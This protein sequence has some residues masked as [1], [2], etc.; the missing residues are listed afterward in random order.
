MNTP[1][2]TK[3]TLDADNVLEERVHSDAFHV[4]AICVRKASLF[5]PVRHSFVRVDLLHLVKVTN[6]SHLLMDSSQDSSSDQ[7]LETM[8]QQTSTALPSCTLGRRRVCRATL[9][10]AMSWE[11][12]V[13]SKIMEHPNPRMLRT[14]NT[15]YHSEPCDRCR[16]RIAGVRW[17]RLCTPAGE[18][19]STYPHFPAESP[20]SNSTNAHAASTSKP[21]N[22]QKAWDH[23]S[24]TPSHT[25][26]EH[27]ASST[28]M[29][30]YTQGDPVIESDSAPSSPR[31]EKLLR[32]V[33]KS[34]SRGLPSLSSLASSV[35]SAIGAAAAPLIASVS[36][37][38][39]CPTHTTPASTASTPQT[40]A[41][42]RKS[43]TLSRTDG[44]LTSQGETPRPT[45]SSQ[46]HTSITTPGGPSSPSNTLQGGSHDIHDKSTMS[47]HLLP[48]HLI[49]KR[50]IS[51]CMHCFD[52]LHTDFGVAP[53][54][55][56]VVQNQEHEDV[57]YKGVL[58]AHMRCL[59]DSASQPLLPTLADEEEIAR[60]DAAWRTHHSHTIH[61]SSPHPQSSSV[62]AHATSSPLNTL[63]ISSEG[64]GDATG[65]RWEKRHIGSDQSIRSSSS[66]ADSRASYPMS[67]SST[68]ILRADMQNF[69][70]STVKIPDVAD[71]HDADSSLA[72][73]VVL[74][75]TPH[76][77]INQSTN[78]AGLGYMSDED[79]SSEA[80]SDHDMAASAG[81]SSDPD[82]LD[83]HSHSSSD[84]SDSDH[85]QRVESLFDTGKRQALNFLVQDDIM[86]PAELRDAIEPFMRSMDHSQKEQA[87]T[88][89]QQQ[90]QQGQKFKTQM[91]STSTPAAAPNPFFLPP[92]PV[93]ELTP[94]LQSELAAH[95]ARSV[96]EYGL[97][98]D[99]TRYSDS[100]APMK[101]SGGLPP[102][103]ELSALDIVVHPSFERDNDP[104]RSA[105]IN[106]YGP[107]TSSSHAMGSGYSE[108][109]ISSMN[110][111]YTE[112]TA[113]PTITSAGYEAT[114]AGAYT[115]PA[116][117]FAPSGY[118][119][120]SSVGHR[121]L[122]ESAFLSHDVDPKI[123][124]SPPPPRKGLDA[125]SYS[126][127][128]MKDL[129]TPDKSEKKPTE[130]E[131]D[132]VNE[133][134]FTDSSNY[135]PPAPAANSLLEDKGHRD[136]NAEWQNLFLMLMEHRA[137][138]LHAM[139]TDPRSM[140]DDPF[141]RERSMATLLREAGVL[142]VQSIE[143]FYA[144]DPFI[145]R[146]SRS[147]SDPPAPH[148][149][150]LDEEL[151][152]M[153]REVFIDG[154]DPFS[155]LER[156]SSRLGEMTHLKSDKSMF[157]QLMLCLIKVREFL[158]EFIDTATR[159][160]KTIVSEMT[161]PL[162]AKTVRPRN[163]GGI[164]GGEKYLEEGIFFK[165]AIDA[166]NV[167]GGDKFAMKAAGHEI[168]GIKAF[169]ECELPGVCVP[170]SMLIDYSG[171]R[172]VASVR[173]PISQ[174]T[175]IYGSSDGGATI[176]QKDP[177]FNRMMQEAAAHLNIKQHEVAPGISL[178]SAVD[179][180]GHKGT[181][182]RYYVLD[183]ARIFPPEPP[184]RTFVAVAIPADSTAPHKWAPSLPIGEIELIANRARWMEQV[185][186]HLLTGH[187]GMVVS[188]IPLLDGQVFY[189]E[190][191]HRTLSI[192]SR[193]S[194]ICFSVIRGPAVLVVEPG[195]GSTQL[196]NLLRA[197]YVARQPHA[198]SSDAFTS[199]GRIDQDIHNTEVED[200]F[201]R[202]LGID[203]PN[204][205]RFLTTS[206]TTNLTHEGLITTIKDFGIN[207]RL[208]GFL[209]SH[210]P[211]TS[212][213]RAIRSMLLIEMVTR[214]A[215][216][217]LR[218][219]MRSTRSIRNTKLDMCLTPQIATR[220]AHEIVLSTFNQ[221]LGNSTSSTYMWHSFMKT[222]IICKYGQY[223]QA[224]TESELDPA[225]DLRSEVNKLQLFQ[226]LIMQ[227]GVTFKNEVLLKFQRNPEL[228]ETAAPFGPNDI[229]ELVPKLKAPWEIKLSQFFKS[230]LNSLPTIT[231]RLEAMRGYF[232]PKG[233]ELGYTALT[234]AHVLYHFEALRSKVPSVIDVVFH[235]FDST[236]GTTPAEVTSKAFFLLAGASLQQGDYALAEA[237]LKAAYNSQRRAL[238]NHIAGRPLEVGGTFLLVVLDKLAC[239]M[240]RLHRKFE[241][242]F[243]AQKFVRIWQ[244]A[245][246]PGDIKDL[247]HFLQRS[248][249]LSFALLWE[250]DYY[251]SAGQRMYFQNGL[252][253]D[254][255]G[256]VYTNTEDFI[257]SQKTA[258][259]YLK[260]NLYDEI[261]QDLPEIS[262]EVR[263]QLEHDLFKP[264]A[265]SSH[266]I[267]E[268]GRIWKG[269]V[270]TLDS[271][272][273]SGFHMASSVWKDYVN[274][275]AWRKERHFDPKILRRAVWTP[276]V[277][278]LYNNSLIRSSPSS[279][280]NTSAF[281]DD[282]EA[283]AIDE[284]VRVVLP[285][286]SPSVSTATLPVTVSD[287]SKT[288]SS[289]LPSKPI[290]SSSATSLS[291][292][293][294]QNSS[295]SSSASLLTGSVALSAASGGSNTTASETPSFISIYSTGSASV[296]TPALGVTSGN[297]FTSTPTSPTS[298]GGGALTTN[299]N[300]SHPSS[301]LNNL[302]SLAGSISAPH[303]LRSGT[304][305]KFTFT[306]HLAQEWGFEVTGAEHFVLVKYEPNV[307]ILPAFTAGRV[308][309][310]TTEGK[311]IL[312]GPE[313]GQFIEGQHVVIAS[314]PARLLRTFGCETWEN[315]DL[316]YGVYQ[317]HL[318][319]GTGL[320]WGRATSI[321]CFVL[322]NHTFV[323]N[324]TA[325]HHV[326][327][328]NESTNWTTSVFQA[329]GIA[330]SSFAFIPLGA[331]YGTAYWTDSNSQLWYGFSEPNGYV[332]N[333]LQKTF[334]AEEVMRLQMNPLI[335]PMPSDF[336][337]TFQQVAQM[338]GSDISIFAN[339]T[340]ANF[341]NSSASSSSGH[342]R[343]STNTLHSSQASNSTSGSNSTAT[344]STA[345]APAPIAG[346]GK[347]GPHQNSP[348][349]TQPSGTPSNN[350]QGQ[351]EKQSNAN[352]LPQTSTSPHT[353]SASISNATAQQASHS[354]HANASNS[355][356]V[357]AVAAAAASL[358]PVEVERA[359]SASS[360]ASHR[361][362]ASHGGST[363]S[364]SLSSS[365][366]SGTTSNSS[367]S[368]KP[369]VL[370][371]EML[372]KNGAEEK[373]STSADN[374][375]IL[376]FDASGARVSLAANAVNSVI[377][378]KSV[379]DQL[380]RSMMWSKMRKVPSL[381][382][383][384]VTKVV[385]SNSHVMAL[386]ANGDIYTWGN[387]LYGELGH[388][389]L[390]RLEEPR[391]VKRLRGKQVR[392]IAA[393]V[394]RS[395]ALISGNRTVYQWGLDFS[396][397]PEPHPFWKSLP[398]EEVVKVVFQTQ[399][400]LAT[401]PN[402]D[403]DMYGPVPGVPKDVQTYRIFEQPHSVTMNTLWHSN[404][405][406]YITDTGRAYLHGHDPY[407]ILFKDQKPILLEI[408][409]DQPVL[410]AAI[411]SNYIVF[412]GENGTI[413]TTGYNEMGQRGSGVVGD[414]AI[415]DASSNNS[416]ALLRRSGG[417][418]SGLRS[419]QNKFM[420]E[421]ISTAVERLATRASELQSEQIA[422]S[423]KNNSGSFGN[424][425][426]SG[427][428]NKN[429][430]SS[431]GGSA[432]NSG[433]HAR[434]TSSS[435]NQ[436]SIGHRHSQNSKSSSSRAQSRSSA[437][438]APHAT[439]SSGR[440]SSPRSYNSS[441]LTPVPSPSNASPNSPHHNQHQSSR[442]PYS[443]LNRSSARIIGAIDENT[444]AWREAREQHPMSQAVLPQPATRVCFPEPTKVVRISVRS[445]KVL[446]LTD[447]GKVWHWG[448]G[449]Y[450][451]MQLSSV[452]SFTICDIHTN[453]SGAILHT[454]PSPPHVLT[455][456]ERGRTRR[457]ALGLENPSLHEIHAR[458]M[459]STPTGLKPY[460]EGSPVP[461]KCH[462]VV[463]IDWKRPFLSGEDLGE[464]IRFVTP[465]S[466]RIENVPQSVSDI[467]IALPGVPHVRGNSVIDYLKPKVTRWSIDRG[468]SNGNIN[469]FIE[470]LLMWAPLTDESREVLMRRRDRKAATVRSIL[471]ERQNKLLNE[472][473][474]QV[475][476]RYLEARN[477]P[478]MSSSSSFSTLPSLVASVH[479]G[480]NSSQLQT[481]QIPQ[482]A[483]FASLPA[484]SVP[485]TSTPPP[486]TQSTP[487]SSGFLTAL[488]NATTTATA[489]GASN[490]SVSI[491]NASSTSPSLTSTEKSS[492]V[493][494]AKPA[495]H[496]LLRADSLSNLGALS[497]L[498]TSGQI[499]IPP[500]SEGRSSS[501]DS[502]SGSQVSSGHLQSKWMGQVQNQSSHS[503]GMHFGGSSVMGSQS[504]HGLQHAHP[505]SGGW[506][507]NAAF[508]LDIESAS[509][510][511]PASLEDALSESSLLD[512][513]NPDQEEYAP[514]I[515]P[516]EYEVVIV[517]TKPSLQ[518]MARSKP[519]RFGY[520]GI[521]ASIEVENTTLIGD[522]P[523][524]AH[525]KCE[526]KLSG[527]CI[528][529][530]DVESGKIV[531]SERLMQRMSD[532]V[533]WRLR[534]GSSYRLYIERTDESGRTVPLC[535][536]S[537]VEILSNASSA[538]GTGSI[539][540]AA[541]N[542]M[543]SD[544]Q[545]CSEW[546]TFFKQCDMPQELVSKYSALF[547][548]AGLETSFIPVLDSG[549]LD[550]LGITNIKD[551]IIIM[552]VVAKHREA[553]VR[554]IL[555]QEL[556]KV[557]ENYGCNSQFDGTSSLLPQ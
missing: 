267:E 113:A 389:D 527:L 137:D 450:I 95:K 520:D 92:E 521:K 295:T 153:A 22:A 347:V 329:Q 350:A 501:V 225:Y 244:S 140:D 309:A 476:M 522:K 35:A 15:K 367:A 328:W 465:G 84:T 145:S 52:T 327:R 312:T 49:P 146:T 300:A 436:S 339:E 220:Q 365:S 130:N 82:G 410:D 531:Q 316:E 48:L 346:F 540:A 430:N 268:K 200:A 29:R 499:I 263:L 475:E 41:K 356:T 523:V 132:G 515:P 176:H 150:I 337:Q 368:T 81:Y 342:K 50:N 24:E 51:L 466:D 460:V 136:W 117:T 416:T 255:L 510:G 118:S 121:S 434:K 116:T 241:A 283:F 429:F 382:T 516:G 375:S 204:F 395:V 203:I 88:R 444:L 462:M 62:G 379:E 438:N 126:E 19:C 360:L 242:W 187:R 415:S 418:R 314:M 340:A 30:S 509:N 257:W 53:L 230:T 185:K 318:V 555:A 481:S 190:D 354:T 182:G 451:P 243:Y 471:I 420:Y 9:A 422:P 129:P 292:P 406:I 98:R 149:V 70:M 313:I 71:S 205:V 381:A 261:M 75:P 550:K 36:S 552:N 4:C 425:G 217:E 302:S 525:W 228:F 188:S 549:L 437:M 530:R 59:F 264:L 218:A 537:T 539:F 333:Y 498:N 424:N 485:T 542:T 421:E 165:F 210:I 456:S 440:H 306:W 58:W 171:Y 505:S 402:F 251:M 294:F 449:T 172:L 432:S 215:K 274:S 413:Y 143:E 358:G 216:N 40:T 34:A 547:V 253:M 154:A 409:E 214:V 198:L 104:S 26:R 235:V 252:V 13:H 344:T 374:L 233:R 23:Q 67:D 89:L 357:A 27:D 248:T 387:N 336:A 396:L 335:V 109:Q 332:P 209:R 158:A 273:L 148:E 173:L 482:N 238:A 407:Q 442:S 331:G 378:R 112:T 221:L 414:P 528:V 279:Q 411:G 380:S 390:V 548:Q 404:L 512:Q 514:M 503:L 7:L 370:T 38:Q 315:L 326:L 247:E 240:D 201:Y 457:K 377:V 341:H 269:T 317:V 45:T 271:D 364:I 489:T 249:P 74:E 147:N 178:Y 131:G 134:Y 110:S 393:G 234:L 258:R 151:V 236:P 63:T 85:T 174:Q 208:L 246:Y 518:V 28:S 461:S 97:N 120:S 100:A 83:A 17:E 285:T 93:F 508:I 308:Q 157:S 265:G 383:E 454:G 159:V 256:N 458:Q 8:E 459:L 179:M 291:S 334:P 57:F 270:K 554:S 544:V 474:Q 94:D 412:I 189:L 403:S 290:T 371:P 321:P 192:N 138:G 96:F 492:L 296:S 275:G 37:S 484:V 281:T 359:Q 487:P 206:Q 245:P 479:P 507:G 167:Y 239:L 142:S 55:H 398:D 259:A 213:N 31:E 320:L 168:Q 366:P 453:A 311:R 323:L 223:G 305:S 488:G 108:T 298:H 128:S 3:D 324:R 135:V 237:Q 355:V 193:A 186:S 277:S 141:T 163:L 477:Q 64:L 2:T 11:R 322:S 452:Q 184:L 266:E 399:N 464:E 231:M 405:M 18:N 480:S 69:V 14:I 496:N 103:S 180:E 73:W 426:N 557:V 401:P 494:N 500:N 54:G 152:A 16:C 495:R 91:P 504:T 262:Q 79:R 278:L 408:A 486:Q 384:K 80:Q 447:Q 361:T 307:Y 513:F 467:S 254:S 472:L 284:A 446:A 222:H 86:R 343:K 21:V 119:V 473:R 511:L 372:C 435:D 161:L 351:Q 519:V 42:K 310:V 362:R 287:L 102:L 260:T 78:N 177:I 543:P 5:H 20:H 349:S 551:Q 338:L 491:S 463:S 369:K 195:Q 433:G 533:R 199:F 160:A 469:R 417:P 345:S 282:S 490:S 139:V 386:L 170:L 400:G 445:K 60:A 133:P 483:S 502:R 197:P 123:E 61:R 224:L 423:G 556:Q 319:T 106:A 156:L 181:D 524:V 122:A 419:E 115:S 286:T 352:Q 297:N 43:S 392:D 46:P 1:T 226:T 441:P 144:P 212:A 169:A 506:D 191:P 272:S 77:P 299:T 493:P 12:Y 111:G 196:F 229:E 72:E 541:L 124:D 39:M 497:P 10:E 293:Y 532:S 276:A 101:P 553:H 289:L 330:F 546:T 227:I 232:G 164:A 33:Q 545:I 529:A 534:V 87:R 125:P 538:F 468:L 127:T 348:A 202:L 99:E 6:S 397:F 175:L 394:G 385:A 65:S 448:N 107:P 155:K 388:G 517:S 250:R 162:E 373:C 44:N 526:L 114:S 428:N 32:P 301:P 536:S 478:I 47:A 535:E 303:V 455:L 391:V 470:P 207:L 325:K 280:S 66:G 90:Q 443:Q 68:H 304:H 76:T 194:A 439:S 431:G 25:L 219:S 166:Y 211:L 376:H 105:H 288:S 363:A 56:K 183:T 353:S 427:A